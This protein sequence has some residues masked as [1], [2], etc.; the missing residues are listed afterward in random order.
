MKEIPL[1]AV[2]ALAEDNP[3]EG[4]KCGESG[5]VVELLGT[6]EDPAYLVEF[7][8][9]SGRAYAFADLRPEQ[10]IVLHRKPSEAA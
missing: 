2:V 1:L 10:L 4:L 3:T 8:D 5:T 7:S 6:E 9:E